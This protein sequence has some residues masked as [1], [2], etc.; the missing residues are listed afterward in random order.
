MNEWKRIFVSVL[1]VLLLVVVVVYATVT[2]Y[3]TPICNG[4]WSQCYLVDGDDAVASSINVTNTSDFINSTSTWFNYSVNLSNTSNIT[5][6]SVL[7]DF[8]GVTGDEN[9]Q[10]KVSWNNGVTWGPVH[11]VHG[12]TSETRYIVDVTS[13]TVW[14]DFKL[15]NAKFRVQG[16]CRL[17]PWAPSG[18]CFIDWLPVQVTYT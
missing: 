6:V 8:W 14:D 12:T 17:E 2:T 1:M 13:D 16:T 10:V 5:N 11:L 18:T 15:S 4:K 9:L 3:H 7:V